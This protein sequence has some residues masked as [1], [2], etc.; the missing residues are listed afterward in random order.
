MKIKNKLTL[1]FLFVSFLNISASHFSP[2]NE[3]K[4][5]Q[6]L[7]RKPQG[8]TLDIEVTKVKTEKINGF[9]DEKNK[10]IK[11]DFSD[12]KNENAK[13]LSVEEK[14]YDV[15]V[16]DDP[17]DIS[18]FSNTGTKNR[19]SIL[20]LPKL[21]DYNLD[22]S[23]NNIISVNYENK[24]ETLYVGIR[25]KNNNEIKKIYSVDTMITPV[26]F[27]VEN[28]I[29][30]ASPFA[31]SNS[32]TKAYPM[33]KVGEFYAETSPGGGNEVNAWKAKGVLG[34]AAIMG[35]YGLL[36]D[37]RWENG[38]I[39][40]T[41][42]G[43]EL[44][45][46]LFGNEIKKIERIKVSN[47]SSY[48]AFKNL[49]GTEVSPSKPAEREIPRITLFLSQ[50][51]SPSK[52]LD[53]G[54][55][56]IGGWN[57]KQ[58]TI[59]LSIKNSY[60]QEQKT[61]IHIPPLDLE[62]F[63]DNAGSSIKIDNTEGNIDTLSFWKNTASVTAPTY[64]HEHQGAQITL[65]DKENAGNFSEDF[66]GQ[67][68]Y[69]GTIKTKENIP[70]P[71]IQKLENNTSEIIYD[72]GF[73][74]LTDEITG[75][76]ISGNV[77]FGENA[78]NATSVSL[79]LA[80][81]ITAKKVYLLL[82]KNTLKNGTFTVTAKKGTLPG[83][84]VSILTI[85]ESNNPFNPVIENIIDKLTITLTKIPEPFKVKNVINLSNPVALTGTST[86]LTSSQ[87]IY[88]LNISGSFTAKNYSGEDPVGCKGVIANQGYIEGGTLGS[89]GL[90][91][92]EDWRTGRVSISGEI[93]GMRMGFSPEQ[94]DSAI[95]GVQLI[96]NLEPHAPYFQ[97]YG[98]SLNN[99][100]VPSAEK[101][102]L[103]SSSFFYATTPFIS[104]SKSKSG[105]STYLS[106]GF[107]KWNYK[108][109]RLLLKY[110]LRSVDGNTFDRFQETYINIPPFEPEAYYDNVNS[111]I[112]IDGTN[113]NIDT[114]NFWSSSSNTA[115]Y[116]HNV[117]GKAIHSGAEIEKVLENNS[118]NTMI[119]LG[120]IRARDL[121]Y[122]SDSQGDILKFYSSGTPITLIDSTNSENKING[123]IIIKVNNG[124][125]S[126]YN[127]KNL[128]T[129]NA[130]I[131]LKLSEALSE[132]KSGDFT[133][134]AGMNTNILRL[135]LKASAN[136][137]SDIYDDI[138]SKITLKISP[139]NLS[140]IVDYQPK[141]LDFG[142]I[143][144]GKFNA[145][146][147]K[148]RINITYD[149]E[150]LNGSNL[151]YELE[152]DGGSKGSYYNDF[153]LYQNGD[154]VSENFATTDIWLGKESIPNKNEPNKRTI[155]LN[156]ILKSISDKAP[157]GNY[158]NTVNIVVSL[159]EAL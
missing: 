152:R 8:A 123:Q 138:I 19:R 81:V 106:F 156:G 126:E 51:E 55:P 2:D 155:D 11:I 33:N 56:A 69:L 20:K 59:M 39:T 107:A 141:V 103:P 43:Y 57:R 41:A 117:N 36:E 131:Y 145:N 28:S 49:A 5:I 70:A 135:G 50:Y 91:K 133:L 48:L 64:E 110:S 147:A 148:T 105:G 14:Q 75:E 158:T 61:Y 140:F 122:A 60:N 144:K 113:Q 37:D 95:K 44:P 102:W 24:P 125:Y 1:T 38:E 85:T 111:S 121:F 73:F 86:N 99:V 77:L 150:K 154:K 139:P 115:S 72:G 6:T 46:Y 18:F 65:S 63:Y 68:V 42:N 22:E 83:E 82:Q 97:F 93:N 76:T 89:Y 137:Q 16:F 153:K 26:A 54:F 35:N 143:L 109:N 10:K 87:G 127:A 53:V 29:I 96:Q 112:K 66:K 17:N 88:P 108:L 98:T 71:Y 119:E 32:L 159:E 129:Q 23:N 15:F 3:I 58:Q 151:I 30:L 114:M 130:T 80:E 94:Y 47:N 124:E 101:K 9:I 27:T 84:R 118:S 62:A 4:T 67:L 136:I 142:K 92:N 12:K 79:K 31:V 128:I 52:H 120:T 21:Y 157:V 78:N 25:D 146:E 116:N 34:S 100:I 7:P 40:I 104:Q 45:A 134:T 13:K 132:S 74:K 90:I 149:N